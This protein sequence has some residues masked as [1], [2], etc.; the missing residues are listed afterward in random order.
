MPEDAIPYT[1]FHTNTEDAPGN[2]AL[3]DQLEALKWIQVNIANFGG[4]PTRITLS[5]ESSGAANVG[6]HILSPLS[7]GLF[8]RALIHSGS[9]LS[10][11][12][13]ETEPLDDYHEQLALRTKTRQI[14]VPGQPSHCPK[15]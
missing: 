12:A 6:H 11:W 10:G 1:W 2:L 4:D 13:L 7:A 9:P 15:N 5:G 14:R 8:Q 3:Y